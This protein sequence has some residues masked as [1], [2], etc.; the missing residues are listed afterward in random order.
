MEALS[1]AGFTVTVDDCVRLFSGYSPD[2]ATANFLKEMGKPLPNN[3]F[4]DQV[5]GS[6]QLFRDRLKPL[7]KDTVIK[8]H[9]VDKIRQ[10][11]ASG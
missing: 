2:A 6:L 9:E 10:C 7:M 11:V 1:N 4:R 8:L 3:F 5:E